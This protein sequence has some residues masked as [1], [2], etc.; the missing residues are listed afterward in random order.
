MYL[1]H[2]ITA[3]CVQRCW[4]NRQTL[5]LGLRL[6][7][8]VRW[9]CL[10]CPEWTHSVQSFALPP[11]SQPNNCQLSPLK[12]QE[13]FRPLMKSSGFQ[14][15]SEISTVQKLS[16][17]K[18]VLSI[19]KAV[20]ILISFCVMSFLFRVTAFLGSERRCFHRISIEIQWLALSLDHF[21]MQRL[22]RSYK[23][24]RSLFLEMLRHSGTREGIF[25]L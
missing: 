23:F 3:V 15:E 7:W 22:F 16:G 19:T 20:F 11:H 18:K 24:R 21:V 10:L 5:S 1:A 2:R 8:C 13:N 12:R 4:I 25:S 14:S 9:V 17:Q 6:C